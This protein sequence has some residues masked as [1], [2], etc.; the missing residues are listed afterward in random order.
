[1]S[2]LHIDSL[3]YNLLDDFRGKSPDWS[4]DIPCIEELFSL[5]AADQEMS[6][7]VGMD[8][9]A[10]AT[11]D[12]G[13]E[14]DPELLGKYTHRQ[15]EAIRRCEERLSFGTLQSL[16]GMDKCH[17]LGILTAA[18]DEI[19]RLKD[20]DRRLQAQIRELKGAQPSDSR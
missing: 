19:Q 15:R 16:L 1:M 4:I 18:I 13:V 17:V 10:T 5:T 14:M 12:V 2:L 8:S 7:D 20:E 11:P 6:P 3:G 9:G